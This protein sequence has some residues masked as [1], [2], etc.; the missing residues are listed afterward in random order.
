[1]NARGDSGH[2]PLHLA[3][4]HVGIYPNASNVSILLLDRGANIEARD[5]SGQT[6]LHAA[7]LADSPEAIAL[8][9][10]RGANA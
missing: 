9:L 1:M 7:V 5:D 3:I 6:P 2:T 4:G 8:L 10:D